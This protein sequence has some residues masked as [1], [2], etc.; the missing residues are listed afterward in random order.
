MANIR[1]SSKVIGVVVFLTLTILILGVGGIRSAKSLS[2]NLTTVYN[3]RVNPLNQLKVVAD[4]FAVGIVDASHKANLGIWTTNEAEISINNALQKYH[5]NWKDYLATSMTNEEQALIDETELQLVIVLPL[6]KEIQQA[7]KNND[8]E[9]LKQLV[10]NDLYKMIDPL[11]EHVSNLMELQLRVAK[12]VVETSERDSS[13]LITAMYVLVFGVTLMAIVIT[14][15]IVFSMRNLRTSVKT[16]SNSMQQVATAADQSSNAIGMVAD[17]SKTQTESINQAVTAV[18][19]SV[20]VLTEVSKSSDKA[21]EVAKVS[22]QAVV[23]GKAKMTTMMEVV[24]R[25]QENSNKINKITEIISGIASQTNM[26]ALNAAI[27]AAR[28][29]ELG[30]GFAVV[31]DQVKTL[32]ESSKNSVDDIVELIDKAKIDAAEAVKVAE[33]VN[34]EMEKIEE[35]VRQTE[36]M[37]QSISTAMEE[38]VSTTEELSHNMDTLR[39]VGASNANAAEEI[40]ETIIELSKISSETNEELKQFNI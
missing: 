22:A 19:Q 20:S 4:A 23:I 5:K 28:A 40:T 13:S 38:Q 34:G 31:A 21:T 6:V 7:L 1:L 25:I 16:I 15:W 2:Q 17:G 29:G 3:D 8:R 32:A 12:E 10:S 24:G 9:K 26:L 18:E 33:I 37:M 14:A 39:D 11:S 36:L 35:G 27:E 30:K